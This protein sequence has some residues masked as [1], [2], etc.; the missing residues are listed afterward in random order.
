[1]KRDSLTD[2]YFIVEPNIGRPTGRSAIAEAGGVE[3]LYTMYCDAVGLPLPANRT[4][5]YKGVKWIHIRFDMQAAIYAW[6]YGDLTFLEWWR[7]IRGPKGYALLSWRDP[8]PFLSSLIELTRLLLSST[9]RK[10]RGL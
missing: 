4:Q 7:S 2:E 9:E 3:L 10:K 6:W 1:M 8:M 5:S